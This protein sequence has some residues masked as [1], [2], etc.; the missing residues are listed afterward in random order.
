MA[1]VE[2][3]A[4]THQMSAGMRR[5]HELWKNI[6]LKPLEH[7]EFVCYSTMNWNDSRNAYYNLLEQ[8]DHNQIVA[9]LAVN[10]YKLFDDQ[11][12]EGNMSR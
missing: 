5:H 9:N 8:D 12:I 1:N 4:Q 7:F 10:V 2:S 11:Y 3:K 6:N